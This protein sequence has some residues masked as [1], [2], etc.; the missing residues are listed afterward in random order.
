ML[1]KCSHFHYPTANLRNVLQTANRFANFFVDSSMFLR[2]WNDS[3]VIIDVAGDEFQ[4]DHVAAVKD[5]SVATK[6]H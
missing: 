5:I 3:L 2:Q 6:I 1:E 4:V